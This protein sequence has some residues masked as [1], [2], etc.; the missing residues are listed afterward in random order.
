MAVGML[1]Q[2]LGGYYHF[3]VWQ[4][5]KELFFITFPQIMGFAMFAMFVQT[6]VSNKFIGH[7][8]VIGVFVLQAVYPAGVGKTRC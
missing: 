8:I 2:A 4:Y 7:G 3:E 6:M 5:V 1:M